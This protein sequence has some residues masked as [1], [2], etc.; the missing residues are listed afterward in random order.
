M[1]YKKMIIEMEQEKEELISVVKEMKNPKMVKYI[2]GF[3]KSFIEL[4]S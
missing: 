1:D 3:V 4:R 2:L